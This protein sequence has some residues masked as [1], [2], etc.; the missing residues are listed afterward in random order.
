MPP[1]YVVAY[2]AYFTNNLRAYNW[3]LRETMFVL[4][5][6]L[7]NRPRNCFQTSCASPTAVKWINQCNMNKY[8]PKCKFSQKIFLLHSSVQYCGIAITNTLQIPQYCTISIT[9][10]P[11]IP[12][13]CAISISDKQVILLQFCSISTANHWR[14]CTTSSIIQNRFQYLNKNQG[15]HPTQ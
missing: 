6:S 1:S 10:T 13:S 8:L 11:G 9:N 15:I 5:N 3:N 7:W 2:G 14:Y 4:M 12:K